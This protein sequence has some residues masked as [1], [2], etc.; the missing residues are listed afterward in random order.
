MLIV[1][2][3]LVFGLAFGSVYLLTYQLYP[4]GEKRVKAYQAK[5]IEESAQTL[6]DMFMDVPAKKR[7]ALLH[8]LS[9]IILGVGGYFAFNGNWPL[10]FSAAGLGII[11]P[12]FILRYKKAQRREKFRQQLVDG[13]MILI[14][15]LRGGLSFLQSIE[16]VSEEM[17][18]PMS[19]EFGL[20][21]REHK[22]GVALEEALE[23]LNKRMPSHELNLVTTATLVSRETGGDIASVFSKLVESFRETSKV[24]EKVKTLTL[25]GK[26]QGIIMSLLPIMFG[27]IVYTT[28]P[29]FMDI[30]FVHPVGKLLLW[31]AL[32]LQIVGSVLILRLSKVDI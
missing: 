32:G 17:P 12:T 28:N 10:T 13:L 1:L 8:I 26:L 7:L 2:P 3:I 29:K 19:E 30:M 20:V 6:D 9:P 5:K 24:M 22:M 4:A 15:S 23:R 27:V 16:V 11:L 18:A 14:S 21:L 31:I 25:Q